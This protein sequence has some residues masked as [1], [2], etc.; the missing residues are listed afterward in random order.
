MTERNCG[1]DKGY[2]S[3][4]SHRTIKRNGCVSKVILKTI[5]MAKTLERDRQITKQIMSYEEVFSFAML[6]ELVIHRNC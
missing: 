6:N 3:K 2:C 5:W 4:E 1:G